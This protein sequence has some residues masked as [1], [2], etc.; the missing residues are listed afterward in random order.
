MPTAEHDRVPTGTFLSFNPVECGGQVLWEVP[1]CRDSRQ[2][3]DNPGGFPVRYFRIVV[4][5]LPNHLIRPLSLSLSLSTE[6]RSPKSLCFLGKRNCRRY[7]PAG[8][9]REYYRT[10]PTCNL[11]FPGRLVIC[12]SIPAD[13]NLTLWPS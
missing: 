6:R 2:Q 11:M 4:H 10:V 13:L 9:K 5:V 12:R 3:I 7:G 8:G 1:R